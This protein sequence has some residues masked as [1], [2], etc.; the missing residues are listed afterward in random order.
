MT[1]TVIRWLVQL[2]LCDLGFDML[3]STA[4]WTWDTNI[5]LGDT[6]SMMG[7]LRK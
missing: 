7:K 4:A 2:K 5:S 1:M 6:D 3:Y